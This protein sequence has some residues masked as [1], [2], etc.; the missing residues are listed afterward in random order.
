MSGVLNDAVMRYLVRPNSCMHSVTA[1]KCV[2]KYQSDIKKRK[3]FKKKKEKKNIF[4][5]TMKKK[6]LMAANN[7]S[8]RTEQYERIWNSSPCSPSEIGRTSTITSTSGDA[9]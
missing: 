1:K 9:W 2:L 5:D 6:R 3:E 4:N 7:R 8:F